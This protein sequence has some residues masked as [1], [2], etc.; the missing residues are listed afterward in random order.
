MIQAAAS[1]AL[2]LQT[3]LLPELG[4]PLFCH[5]ATSLLDRPLIT[6]AGAHRA[7]PHSLSFGRH[8]AERLAAAGFAVA[9]AAD[10]H[11]GVGLLSLAAQQESEAVLVAPRDRERYGLPKGPAYFMLRHTG[12]TYAVGLEMDNPDVRMVS[13]RVLVD[14]T[15]F[16][17]MLWP[18]G[19]SL[20]RASGAYR[21]PLAT[22]YDTFAGTWLASFAPVG[23]TGFVVIV[24]TPETAT[25]RDQSL[26]L[27][28]AQWTASP[29]SQGQHWASL[30]PLVAS[31]LRSYAG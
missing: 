19:G 23:G 26:F 1:A 9:A 21:D 4:H 11:T 7:P 16:D 20:V 14:P 5:G 24:Q 28:L 29:A 3:L 12:V 15:R 18:A 31:C 2:G 10:T 6:L 17:R 13:D 22:I 25:T 8:L 27:Q 30:P